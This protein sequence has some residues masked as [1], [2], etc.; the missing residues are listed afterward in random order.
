[1]HTL[2]QEPTHLDGHIRGWHLVLEH[3]VSLVVGEASQV[4]VLGGRG[5][6]VDPF[7]L[8]EIER[9]KATAGGSSIPGAREVA[10]SVT[11]PE[12]DFG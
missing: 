7:Q 10:G 8:E 3:A 9:I 5:W 4:V 1:M 11:V 12:I 6:P 2:P